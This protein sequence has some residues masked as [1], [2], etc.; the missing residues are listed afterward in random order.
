MTNASPDDGVL[1]FVDRYLAYL[2]GTDDAPDITLLDESQRTAALQRLHALELLD[3]PEP[4][5]MP[6]VEDDPVAKRFGFDRT[7]L[8][9]TIST[10]ALKEAASRAGVPFSELAQRLTAGGRPTRPAELLRLT[11]TVTADVERDLAARFAAILHTTVRDLEAAG[12]VRGSPTFDDY[13]ALEEARALIEEL[14]AELD[15]SF[16]T[17]ERRSRELVGAAAFRN[18]TND[19]WREALLGALTQIRDEHRR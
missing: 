10:A 14:A 4:Y 11:N 15:I 19:A 12:S 6:P 18:Y 1:D 9:I 3:E 5:P 2:T 13:L 8:T 16:E 17:I 7:E